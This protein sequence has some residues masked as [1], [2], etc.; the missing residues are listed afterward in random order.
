MN[1]DGTDQRRLTHFRGA[2]SANAWLADGRIVFAHFYADVPLPHWYV[3]RPDGSGLRS[4]PQ[5]Y[6]AGK[7]IDWLP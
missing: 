2:D 6:G 1:A 4:L 7:P 3:I 5:L